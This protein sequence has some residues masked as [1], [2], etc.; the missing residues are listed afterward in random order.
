MTFNFKK[1]I[2][3]FSV[4]YLIAVVF[5]YLFLNGGAYLKILRYYLFL[6]S[7]ISYALGSNNKDYYLYIPKIDVSA[8]IIFSKDNS[9]KSILE[10]LEK[11]VGFYP[12]YQL[13]GQNG[14]SVILGHSSKTDWYKGEYAYIFSLLGKLQEGDEFYVT[15]GNSKLIYKVFSS[16]ILT[17]RQA[18]ELLSRKPENDSVIALVTCWP[19]G[20]SSKR[21]VIQAKLDHIE[22]M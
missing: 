14:L 22:K 16:D 18:D 19:I 3:I 20:F 8:P 13:P 6:D 4:I 15:T 2:A 10:G 1:E 11:C 21:T 5:I 12:G 9:I 7:K 17:P